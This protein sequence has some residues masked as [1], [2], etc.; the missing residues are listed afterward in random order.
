V[1]AHAG[2]VA[3]IKREVEANDRALGVLDDHLRTWVEG[4]T[5]RCAGSCARS[6]RP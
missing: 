4:D 2:R 1:V 3:L 5:V 6:A